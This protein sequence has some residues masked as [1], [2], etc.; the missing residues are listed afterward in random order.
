LLARATISVACF[1]AFCTSTEAFSFDVAKISC[2]SFAADKP[3]AIFFA[4][5]F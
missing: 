5:I 1:L 2:P 4:S 3:S